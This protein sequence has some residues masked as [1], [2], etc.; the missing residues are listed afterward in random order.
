MV[1]AVFFDIDGTLVS[2]NTHAVPQSAVESVN[3]LRE[4]GIK[5]IIAT[6]RRIQDINNLGVLEF[7]GY[8]T[9]NGSYCLAGRDRVVFKHPIMQEDIDSLLSYMETEEKFPCVFV[10][11][12]EAN[13]NYRDDTVEKVFE[14][15]HFPAPIYKPLREVAH[16]KVYQLIS[17]FPEHKEAQIMSALPHC[18]TTRWNPMFT[19]V[20][21]K[22]IDKSIGIDKMLEYFDI[23]LEDTMAF[24][25]GGNDKAM[26]Q[27][28]H[29]GIALGNAD[30]DV[31]QVADYITDS[32][33]EDGVY[34]ALKHFGLL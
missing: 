10:H 1:K 28:V 27:H 18:N 3:Q 19:D 5:V 4:K 17:F 13:M 30:D 14:L 22:G 9:M 31:K 32:V 8:I 7:D 34:N 21:P 23:S 26:L 24:G 6:G 15:L 16:K 11:E 20:V 25:D 12:D 33:D 29:T 2:F